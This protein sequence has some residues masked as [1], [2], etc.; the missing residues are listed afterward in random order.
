VISFGLFNF[1]ANLESEIYLHYFVKIQ[2][3]KT[4]RTKVNLATIKQENSSLRVKIRFRTL[5]SSSK[6][7]VDNIHLANQK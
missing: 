6:N 7:S 4:K 1:L 3:D 2:S 5:V